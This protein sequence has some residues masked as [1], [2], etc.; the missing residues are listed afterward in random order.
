[1]I[2]SRKSIRFSQETE[3]LAQVMSPQT[4]LRDVP[5]SNLGRNNVSEVSDFSFVS[6]SKFGILPQN[7]P[8]PFPLQSFKFYKK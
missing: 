4:C 5:S 1:M 6:Q 3:K 7:K 8:R 2:S